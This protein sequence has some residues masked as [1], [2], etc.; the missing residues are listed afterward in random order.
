M[1]VCEKRCYGS[2]LN[3]ILFKHPLELLF[4]GMLFYTNGYVS[5][6]RAK[7]RLKSPGNNLFH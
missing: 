7:Q 4:Q 2:K 1:S 6:W 5:N 3:C